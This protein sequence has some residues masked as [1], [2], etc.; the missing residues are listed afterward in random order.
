MALER[1]DVEKIAHLARLGL[2]DAD[3]PRTTEALNSILGLIDQ[4]QA[5][6][7]TGIEPL[8]HPLE[9]SQRLRADVVTETN[10]REAYQSIAP[11]VEDGLYL[12]PKVIE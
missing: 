2:N 6:D 4:M 5:V 8:A 9:A 3:I 7:T 11:A 10:H 12:V 1:S